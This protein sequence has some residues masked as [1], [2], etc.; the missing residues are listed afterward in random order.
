M[1]NDEMRTA[2]AKEIAYLAIKFRD[3][4]PMITISSDMEDDERTALKDALVEHL[5]HPPRIC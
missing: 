3:R 4:Q 1:L 5:R 2:L